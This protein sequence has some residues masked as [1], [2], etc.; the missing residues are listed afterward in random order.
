MDAFVRDYRSN[1]NGVTVAV[2]YRTNG[3]LPTN[4]ESSRPQLDDSGDVVTFVSTGGQIVSGDTNNREDAF[5]RNWKAEQSSGPGTQTFLLGISPTGEPGLCPGIPNVDEGT[6]DISTRSYLSGD[7]KV[8]V[9]ISGQCNL[10]P[11]TA[12][13]GADTN[14]FADAFVRTF[15]PV[16][17]DPGTVNYR[18]LAAPARLLDTRPGASTADGQQ[19][20]IGVRPAGSVLQLPVAGRAGIPSGTASVV[21]NVTVVGPAA[22]GFVTVFPCGQARPTAS[23]INYA[24]GQTIPN[25]VLSKLG[26]GGSAGRMCLYTSAA[27]H[28]LVDAGG[29]FASTQ[30]YTPLAAP[31][32]LLDTRPGAS[33]VD[34]QFAGIGARTARSITVLPVRRAGVPNTAQ[35]VVLNV[36]AVGAAADGF[37]TVFPCGQ[38]V[39]T[40]SNLNYRRGEIIANAVVAKPDAT[41]RVCLFTSAATHLLADIGGYFPNNVTYIPLATPARLMDTRPSPTVDGQFSNI[42]ARVAGSTTALGVSGRGGVPQGAGAVVLNVTAVAPFAAGFVTV[43]PCDQTRPTASNL[44]FP[45]RRTIPNAVVTKLSAGGVVC[46]YTSA[47]TNLIVDVAGTLT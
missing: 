27:T 46:L 41:G 22:A 8:V 37:V 40:V 14:F 12:F 25:L 45:A 30:T 33:T 23:N 28:L 1:A 43:F 47:T 16:P 2:G 10:T 3:T 17:P 7:G 39:P 6:K 18:A 29:G 42:G 9:F 5:I 21:A 20:G 11:P 26:T 4:A 31:A 35:S 19:A 34:G 32:R 44:N 13:G 38:A 15:R 24:R 36:A